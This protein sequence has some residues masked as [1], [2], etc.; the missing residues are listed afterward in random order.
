MVAY[1]GHP[2]HHLDEKSKLTC[3]FDIGLP[4]SGTLE[5]AIVTK[6]AHVR[7][8]GLTT[9]W[10]ARGNAP[11][12]H[13][14]GIPMISISRRRAFTAL[15]VAGFVPFSLQGTASAVS[16]RSPESAGPALD[17]E[18][19]ARQIAGGLEEF[20]TRYMPVKNNKFTVNEE[21]VRSDGYGDK[22]ERFREM[23]HE[24]NA[25]AAGDDTSSGISTQSAGSYAKCVAL[26]ALGIPA[27][28]LSAGTWTAIGT[29]MKAYKW[30]L[31]AS[32]IVRAL[33]PAALKGV[34]KV[35]GG[36]AGIAA[37]LAGSAL[38]CAVS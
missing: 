32:T 22:I 18:A 23:A 25:S 38:V 29:A 4:P 7:F 11:H 10:V 31:A 34:L 2:A 30:G 26:G 24:M 12:A 33:G 14:K 17:K 36:P 27:G 37:A 5:V 1:T 28:A 9:N 16:P 15:C 8:V 6:A 3:E 13:N 20:F 19:A 35:A 21:A